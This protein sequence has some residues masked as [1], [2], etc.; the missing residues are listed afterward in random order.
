M[1]KILTAFVAVLLPAVLAG[2]GVVRTQAAAPSPS[3]LLPC[4]VVTEAPGH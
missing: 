2:C 1:M 3:A 4:P